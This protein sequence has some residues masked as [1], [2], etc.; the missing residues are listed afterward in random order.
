MMSPPLAAGL[1]AFVGACLVA[2][3]ITGFRNRS[4]V[5][6]LGFAFLAL[7]GSL[8]ALGKVSAAQDLGSTDPAMAL[9]TKVLLIICLLSFLL[10]AISAV[11][12]TL[13]RVR[14]VRTQ[15][16]SAAETLLALVQASRD[17]KEEPR[18]GQPDGDGDGS[19]KEDQA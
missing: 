13:R 10:S 4:Y 9:L 7:S 19:S 18:S 5:G 3:W 15:H 17:R 1:L 11:R 8:W 6:W 16:E 2:G 12:E 14:E